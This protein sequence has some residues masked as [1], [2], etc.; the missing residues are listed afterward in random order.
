MKPLF[1]AALA[2]LSI[3]QSK[4]CKAQQTKPVESYIVGEWQL[5]DNL[6]GSGKRNIYNFHSNK[7]FAYYTDKEDALIE[8]QSIKGV[9]F[10]RNDTLFLKPLSIV[11][12]ENFHLIKDFITT[13]NDS[14]AL[15]GG[16]LKTIKVTDGHYYPVI[17]KR[18]D[19]HNL[20]LIN[21]A[22]YF[23]LK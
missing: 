8:I 19:K 1:Y 6:I 11:K 15:V 17:V 7:S 9:Y 16:N 2:S 5:N 3:Q 20:L 10:F 23:K 13:Q 12:K 22:K 14:W 4:D 21:S 18:G